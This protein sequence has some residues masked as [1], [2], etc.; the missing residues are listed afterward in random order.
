MGMPFEHEG[1]PYVYIVFVPDSIQDGI[2]GYNY[3]L[4]PHSGDRCLMAR[5]S[6]AKD[7]S[8]ID[9]DDWLFSPMLSGE[10]QTI[11][12]FANDTEPD[13]SN[14]RYYATFEV[15]YSTTGLKPDDF[16]RVN[17]FKQEDSHWGEYAFDVPAGAQ[18]FAIRN[19]TE[20]APFDGLLIDDISYLAGYGLLEG[21]NVY[22]D[23]ELIESLPADATSFSEAQ[24][25]WGRHQYAV[26]AVF[27]GG[28]SA[29]ATSS[30]LIF[31]GITTVQSGSVTVD[32]QPVYNLQGQRVGVRSDLQR[33]PKG[34]YVV[35]GKKIVVR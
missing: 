19:T 32:R 14:L 20:G 33:L 31:T 1:E 17:S 35:D 10:A 4:K 24:M 3:S 23:R 7:Y 30:D 22:R 16:T 26:T 5:Y 12:F 13:P 21:F 29:L 28:E 15:L 2:T 6:R 27:A 18:Y 11:K 25:P 8:L 34:V 9:S